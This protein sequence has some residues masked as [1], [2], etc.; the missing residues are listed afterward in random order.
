MLIKQFDAMKMKY[1][2]LFEFYTFLT[3]FLLKKNGFISKDCWIEW[4]TREHMSGSEIISM[5][6]V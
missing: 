5:F 2:H 1:T 6:S 3:N 4:M